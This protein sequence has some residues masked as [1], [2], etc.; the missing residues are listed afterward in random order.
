MQ[1]GDQGA[2]HFKERDRCRLDTG[3]ATSVRASQALLS[4][5]QDSRA[6]PAAPLPARPYDTT[7][8]SAKP[9]YSSGR[10]GCG[11]GEGALVAARPLRNS[12]NVEKK[13]A[14]RDELRQ[15]AGAEVIELG[16][17]LFDMAI[18]I[19]AQRPAQGEE[20]DA[21]LIEDMRGAA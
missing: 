9:V 15:R 20:V 12:M 2:I 18:D 13:H 21:L 16:E 6:L 4:G 14:G 1:P 5:G 8:G 11:R 10:G 7:K 19:A 3:W 17:M